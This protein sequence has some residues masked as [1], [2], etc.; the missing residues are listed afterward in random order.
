MLNGPKDHGRGS[1]AAG[2]AKANT[3]YKAYA[4]APES[5]VYGVFYSDSITKKDVTVLMVTFSGKT[6][7]E[8]VTPTSSACG[9]VKSQMRGPKLFV[10]PIVTG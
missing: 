4:T 3:T 6:E 2:I 5:A 9:S 8:S 7:S 1:L 10:T